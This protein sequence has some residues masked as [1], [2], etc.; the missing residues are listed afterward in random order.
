MMTRLK[1]RASRVRRR[2][3]IRIRRVRCTSTRSGTHCSSPDSNDEGLATSAFNKS[4]LIPNKCHTCLMDK[5]KKVFTHETPKYTSSSDEDLDDN[6]D[7]SDLFRRL[8][9]S[10]VDKINELVDALN[11]KNRL[12][13]KQE[14]LLFDEQYKVMLGGIPLSKVLKNLTNMF[15]V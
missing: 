10:K 15:S 5:E 11:D 7:Y 13:E 9:R 14:D 3:S 8:E 2:S 1:T 6:A 4:T 12:I